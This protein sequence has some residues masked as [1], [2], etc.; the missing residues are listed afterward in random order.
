MLEHGFPERIVLDN[1]K[2]TVINDNGILTA[3]RYGEDWPAADA[4]LCGDKLS[5]AMVHRIIELEGIV[6]NLLDEKVDRDVSC[7]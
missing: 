7:K 5:L 6:R 4:L 1:G 2:Y 3:K